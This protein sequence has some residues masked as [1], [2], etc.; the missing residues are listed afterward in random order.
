LALLAL[1]AL[2]T[3]LAL[4][5]LLAL[6]TLVALLP[7][8]IELTRELVDLPLQLLLI[9]A[10]AL[11]PALPFF[12]A[13]VCA[14]E[15]LLLAAQ[16]LLPLRHL[17]HPAERLAFLVLLLL[18]VCTRAGAILVVGALLALQLAV[19]ERRQILIAVAASAASGRLILRLHDLAAAHLR[20]DLQ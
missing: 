5:R 9:E 8:L 7:L 1:L 20:F 4:L 15:R 13:E 18:L 17:T 19:E 10:Q 12:G 11:Q 3:L 6:L 2:L 14:R 16:G